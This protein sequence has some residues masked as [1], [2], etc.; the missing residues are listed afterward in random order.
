MATSNIVTNQVFDT[1]K[2]IDHAFRRCKIAPQQ[3]TPEYIETAKDLLF[4]ILATLGSKGVA[5]WCVDQQI[6]GLYS[7]QW[8]VDLPPGTVDVLNVNLRNVQRLSGTS[9]SSSGVAANAFDGDLETS[10]T[11]A[12]GVGYIELDFESTYFSSVGILPGSTSSWDISIQ[13][14]SDGVAWTTRYTNSSVSVIDRSWLW[15][16]LEGVP[17]NTVGVRLISGSSTTLSVRELVVGNSP[18]EVPLAKVNRDQ[19][20]N[21]NNRTF[22]S[23]PTEYWYNKTVGP[24]SLKIWPAPSD[25]FKFFHLVSYLQRHPQDVGTLTQEIEVPRRWKLAIIGELAKE[26][27]V[28]I[29]EVKPEVATETA[30]YAAARM[31]EAWTSE[32]D[33][34]DIQILPRIGPY[35]R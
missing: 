19:Y 13:T 10:C 7:G 23:R 3:I 35:T 31:A 17:S 29:P 18:N 27:S 2:V 15:F 4:L 21:L 34:S 22:R 14:T 12:P 28:E 5:L 30:A 20:S 16:D 11:L 6:L 24:S 26:L 25:D 33:G 9:S 1:R 32:T 8:T